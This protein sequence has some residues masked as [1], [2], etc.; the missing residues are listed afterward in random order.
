[1][2]L[3]EGSRKAKL[4]VKIIFPKFKLF[5]DVNITFILNLQ[6]NKETSLIVK[7]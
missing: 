4:Y 7:S 2:S 1:M 5:K 3:K 6:E